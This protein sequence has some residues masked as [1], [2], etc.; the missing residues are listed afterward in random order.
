MMNRPAIIDRGR[1]PEIAGTRITVFHVLE[2]RRAGM[3]RDAIAASLGVSSDQVEAALS[4]I[5]E[6]EAEVTGQYEEIRKRIERGNPPWIEAKFRE[7]HAKLE[8]LRK[9]L[10][11]N[12]S[13]TGTDAQ[14][15]CVGQ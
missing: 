15:T 2:Y 12:V 3:H 9:R 6:H 8:A 5:R 7:S 11:A 13:E 1:G 14:G 4:Y 10:A